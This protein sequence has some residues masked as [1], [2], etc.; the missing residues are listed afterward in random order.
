MA[1]GHTDAQL[2]A[3]VSYGIPGTAMVAW[4]DRLTERQRLD[5]IAY[6]KTFAQPGQAAAPATLAPPASTGGAPTAA[7]RAN[8]PAGP[9]S[10]G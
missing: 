10:G 8:A 7:P 5:V 3:W 2:L 1:A 6:I 9:E 4:Q